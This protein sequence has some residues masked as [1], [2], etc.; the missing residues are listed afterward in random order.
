MITNNIKALFTFV[1]IMI[2]GNGYS[3]PSFS[4]S[5]WFSLTDKQGKTVSANEFNSLNAYVPYG[6]VIV[7][8]YDTIA[9]MYNLKGESVNPTS[10]LVLINWGDTTAIEFSVNKGYICLGNIALD[11]NAYNFI[12]DDRSAEKFNCKELLS[13]YTNKQVCKTVAPT[14][15]FIVDKLYETDQIRFDSSGW[16][17]EK[18]KLE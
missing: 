9:D 1:L 12:L 8:Q 4:F 3:Q 5:V 14:S 2:Y 13:G 17:W 16:G 15:S 11:G 7:I 18:L 6:S 10:S